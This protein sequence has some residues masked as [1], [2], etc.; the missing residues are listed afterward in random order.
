MVAYSFIIWLSFMPG[1]LIYFR[2]ICLQIEGLMGYHS[3][4]VGPLVVIGLV[5]LVIIIR[6]FHVGEETL[7]FGIISIVGYVLFLVWAQTTTPEGPIAVPAIANP[8][9]LTATISM[10]LALHDF[11]VAN[12]IKNPNRS[13][14][15]GI[16]RKTFFIGVCTYIFICFSSFGT[17]K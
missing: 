15:H 6:I 4:S 12:I 16:V 10:A 13:E 1:L 14:Y 11:L 3:D 2:I 8:V 17:N 9:K 7:A 5:I